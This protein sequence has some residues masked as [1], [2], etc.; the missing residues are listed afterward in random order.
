MYGSP[1]YCKYNF[2]DEVICAN[3]FGVFL[4][5]ACSTMRSA[6]D[7]PQKAESNKVLFFITGPQ[8]SRL[9]VWSS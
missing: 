7:C 2:D 4:G 9:I 8:P 3:V 1:R 6:L 5:I